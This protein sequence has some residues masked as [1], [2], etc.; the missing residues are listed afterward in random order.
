[1]DYHHAQGEIAWLQKQS[2]NLILHISICGVSYLLYWENQA[3]AHYSAG[4][5]A[6][7]TRIPK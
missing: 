4:F 5:D 6:D 7:V 3:T 1:V 2:S